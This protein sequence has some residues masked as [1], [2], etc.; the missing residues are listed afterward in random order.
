MA[1]AKRAE[2]L[3]GEDRRTHGYIQERDIDRNARSDAED[4]ER[5]RMAAE[6]ARRNLDKNGNGIPDHLESNPANDDHV[7]FDSSVHRNSTLSSETRQA[8]GI[9][10]ATQE[11]DEPGPDLKNRVR[12]ANAKT[13]KII[14]EDDANPKKGDFGRDE[15]SKRMQKLRGKTAKNG[16]SLSDLSRLSAGKTDPDNGFEMVKSAW[17]GIYVAAIS[18]RSRQNAIK[19]AERNRQLQ[20]M[21]AADKALQDAETQAKVAAKSLDKTEAPV[22]PSEEV[23]EGP[24][25]E[26]DAK[27]SSNDEAG[28]SGKNAPDQKPQTEKGPDLS[29]AGPGSASNQDGDKKSADQK[30]TDVSPSPKLRAQPNPGEIIGGTAMGALV[31]TANP[32][33]GAGLAA[34]QVN[35]AQKDA[36]RDFDGPKLSSARKAN[37]LKTSAALPGA[38]VTSLENA[39]PNPEKMRSLAAAPS[40]NDAA[41]PRTKIRIAA[42]KRKGPLFDQ[43]KSLARP[44]KPVLSAGPTAPTP[45]VRTM[46][47]GGAIGLFTKAARKI[48]RENDGPS[49]QERTFKMRE[50]SE[51]GR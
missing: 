33:L 42:E 49:L 18:M 47:L 25:A 9:V 48:A 10:V 4:E 28:K 24:N 26:K 15:L 38:A 46:G 39:R 2:D 19:N 13:S 43:A 16:T 27:E 3:D 41:L 6:N 44:E 31:S 50:S 34:M 5:E 21:M 40:A 1:D 32:A 29:S 7:R 23:V 30:E 14:Q 12:E 11:T 37:D 45:R 17:R 8:A 36:G 22:T 51:R 20:E 35:E